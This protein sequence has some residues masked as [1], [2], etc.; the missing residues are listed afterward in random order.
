M[1]SRIEMTGHPAYGP[2]PVP[3]EN[4]KAVNFF[5]GANAAGK[6]SLCKVIK[7]DADHPSCKVGWQNNSPL[8]C[9]VYDREF[10]EANLRDLKG[11]FTL[12]EQQTQAHEELDAKRVEREEISDRIVSLRRALIGDDGRGGVKGDLDQAEAHFTEIAWAERTANEPLKEAISPFWGKKDSFRNKILLEKAGNSAS[13]VPLE[14]LHLKASKLLGPLADAKDL[15]PLVDAQEPHAEADVELLASPIVGKDD[16]DL[17]ALIR[18]LSNSDWVQQ[19]RA[20]LAES[21]GV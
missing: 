8:E 17:A 13:L 19:G 3:V 5:F 7:S 9:L 21:G 10:V 2:T 20:Y 14:R 12:G 15:L 6:S 18:A 16:V 4:F 1:I 11:V